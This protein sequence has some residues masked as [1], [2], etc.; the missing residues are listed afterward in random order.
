MGNEAP[1]LTIN[2]LKIRYITKE[3]STLAIDNISLTVQDGEFVSIVGPSGCGKSTLLKAVSGLLKAES[4]EILLD[5]RDVQGVPDS[6]GFVFQNDAL[7]PWKTVVDN[8]R[9]PLEVKGLNIKEQTAQAV[10]LL[11]S[12]G[13]KNFEQYYPQQ[14]SGGM[15]KRVALAR[16][17]AYDPDLYLMDEPFGPLDAQTRVKIG[18]A[19]LKMWEK[20]GKSVLFVTHDIEEAIVLS[21][22]VI[23]MSK[24][25]GR[26]KAEFT[27]DIERPRPYYDARFD[28]RFKELQK[29][30][31]DQIAT[32]E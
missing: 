7:L 32:E 15:R 5:G 22:R 1:K 3:H 6:V 12:V 18:S 30:I 17:F 26:I 29:E 16:S 25:P 4:G 8:V 24:R 20:V 28:A 21:D 14:L 27:I 2:N 11:D 23:V 13:L 31:W 19:F 9:L 10:S